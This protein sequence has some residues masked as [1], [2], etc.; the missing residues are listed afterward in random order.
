MKLIISILVLLL[1]SQSLL[2]QKVVKLWGDNPDDYRK[3]AVNLYYYAPEK[4]NGKA[5]IFCPG[6]SYCYLSMFYEGHNP[7][8]YFATLGYSSFVLEYR[9]GMKGNRYPSQISDLQKAMVHIRTNAETYNVKE[10]KLAV[11]GFSAGGHLVGTSG[12]YWQKNYVDIPKGYDNQIVRPDAVAMIYP[13]VSM[14]DSIA[15]RKSRRNLLGQGYSKAMKDSMSLELNV[16]PQMP[17]VLVLACEDDPIVDYHN[18]VEMN[19]A[20]DA[21][22]VTHRFLL[23]KTGGH[24]F[25]ISPEKIKSDD[26]SAAQWHR[27]FIKMLEETG[28]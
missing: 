27:E 24:G 14:Q 10:G 13:V 26:K 20:L 28:F 25:G 22:G 8:R 5:I 7:A 18:A 9:R 11:C 23:H 2:A 15:H 17:P 4:S 16:H 6:G 21:Q 19:R 1:A 12:V 3:K